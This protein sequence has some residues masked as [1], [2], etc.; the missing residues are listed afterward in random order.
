MTAPTPSDDLQFGTAEP[1][2]PF[3]PGSDAG[4]AIACA[5]CAR[6]IATRYWTV[7]GRTT[8]GD[9]KAKVERALAG[10][11][12]TRGGRIAKS[13][14]LGL[15]AAVVGAALWFGVALWLG[16]SLG[17]V[18]LATGWLVGRAVQVGSGGRGGRRYQVMAALLAYLPVVLKSYAFSAY[19]ALTYGATV[20]G[21]AQDPFSLFMF[22]DAFVRPIVANLLAM[23]RGLISLAIIAFGIHQA[24]T[25]NAQIEIPITGPHRIGGAPAREASA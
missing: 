9:C 5:Q 3:T 22:A 21:A 15:G 2:T 4:A 12:S 20:R 10:E 23:P 25:M 6:P 1:T 18:A 17:I 8:C 14:A 7:A 19:T 24:W 16:G 11:D 13:L